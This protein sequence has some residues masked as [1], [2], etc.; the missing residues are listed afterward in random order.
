MGNI[1][2]ALRLRILEKLSINAYAGGVC[3]VFVTECSLASKVIETLCI[4][5]Q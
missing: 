4:N 5:L 3:K 1:K 2:T